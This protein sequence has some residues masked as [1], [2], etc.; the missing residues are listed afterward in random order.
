MTIDHFVASQ[1]VYKCDH[2]GY[3]KPKIWSPRPSQAKIQKYS[4]LAPEGYLEKS[5]YMLQNSDKNCVPR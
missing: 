5:P 3:L 1:L 4:I 2:C